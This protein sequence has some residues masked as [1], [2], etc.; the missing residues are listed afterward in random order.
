V[1]KENQNATYLTVQSRHSVIVFVE[2]HMVFDKKRRRCE[3]MSHI[4][5]PSRDVTRALVIASAAKQSSPVRV[6]WIAL[7]RCSSQ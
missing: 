6:I 2:A 5:A 7:S 1:P 3:F 4:V